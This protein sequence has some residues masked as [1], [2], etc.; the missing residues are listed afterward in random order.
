MVVRTGIGTALAP[1]PFFR[2]I[3]N[4]WHQSSGI[5]K[6]NLSFFSL[7]TPMF[8]W[9]GQHFLTRNGDLLDLKH[10]AISHGWH[11]FFF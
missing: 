4:G 9:F 1:F 8:G 2:V 5:G 11:F 3:C 6:R 7:F 10:K